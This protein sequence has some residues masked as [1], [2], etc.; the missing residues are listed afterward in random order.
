MRVLIPI[1]VTV[2]NKI[3]TII[4][5]TIYY[6]ILLICIFKGWKHFPIYK[7]IYRVV[8]LIVFGLHHFCFLFFTV[9]SVLSDKGFIVNMQIAYLCHICGFIVIVTV[10]CGGLTEI[11]HFLV[12]I[13]FEYI[14]LG[15][16]KLINWIKT[17]K[18]RQ[19]LRNKIIE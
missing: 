1:L 15:I 10:I 6:F 3:G 12:E 14:F 17:K 19:I 7:R 8:L 18:K 5:I 11:I 2:G 13:F 16:K 4:I 9:L